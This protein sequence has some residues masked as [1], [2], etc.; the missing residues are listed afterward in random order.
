VQALAV[1]KFNFARLSGAGS[2]TQSRASKYTRLKREVENSW[3]VC[4]HP[5]I[6]TLCD[7][8]FDEAQEFLCLVMELGDS[9]VRVVPFCSKV[10]LR[11]S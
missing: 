2:D 11:W 6:V 8:I 3:R 9:K 7:V 10:M 5:A 4:D 1:K